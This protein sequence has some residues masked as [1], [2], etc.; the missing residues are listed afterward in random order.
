MT[1]LVGGL[2]CV[3]VVSLYRMLELMQGREPQQHGGPPAGQVDEVSP[4]N[5]DVFCFFFVHNNVSPKYDS[6][7][8]RVK[9]EN[10]TCFIG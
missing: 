5:N 8:L 3:V 1:V 9:S 7:S 10:K 2:F 4:T 6:V